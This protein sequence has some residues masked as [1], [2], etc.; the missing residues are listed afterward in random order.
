MNQTFNKITTTITNSKIFKAIVLFFITLSI[1]CCSLTPQQI[2]IVSANKVRIIAQTEQETIS[3]YCIPK[4][5]TAKSREEVA[6]IDKVCLKAETSYNAVK[7]SWNTLIDIINLSK[8]NK[9]TDI[10]IQKEAA[11]LATL[12]AGLKEVIKELK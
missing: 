8:L 7:L 3:N 5:K 9:A 11:N 1:S 4:Y 6:N 10:D 12:L 2:A